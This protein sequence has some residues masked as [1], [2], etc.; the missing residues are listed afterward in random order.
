MNH[1]LLRM[2]KFR[3]FEPDYVSFTKPLRIRLVFCKVGMRLGWHS[4][5]KKVSERKDHLA[6]FRTSKM[7]SY[8]FISYLA[9]RIQWTRKS[10]MM[11]KELF[12]L[13]PNVWQNSCF[14]PNILAKPPMQFPE[15]SVNKATRNKH[16]LISNVKIHMML[17]PLCIA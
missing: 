4:R 2:L 12:L 7:K 5:E 15:K 11:Q 3:K 17:E 6:K 9:C 10:S 16:L 13:A 8:F 1:L 14:L